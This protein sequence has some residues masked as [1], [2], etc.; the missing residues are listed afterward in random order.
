MLSAPTA[1]LTC[2]PSSAASDLHQG[3]QRPKPARCLTVSS[4]DCKTI[5][6][7]G[8]LVENKG[9]RKNMSTERDNEGR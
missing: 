5:R 2:A 6:S 1:L 7:C 9:L 3:A 8:F 4:G